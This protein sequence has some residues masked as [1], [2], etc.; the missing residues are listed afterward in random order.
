ML[1]SLI[2]AFGL[3]RMRS[4]YNKMHASSL[5]DSLGIPM[6]ILGVVISQYS[7]AI[8]PKAFLLILLMFITSPTTCNLLAQ[9]RYNA[10][11]RKYT[12]HDK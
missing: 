1:S 11:R 7:I 10:K 3:W 12:P 9:A 8:L 2:A 6:I 4:F 5:N